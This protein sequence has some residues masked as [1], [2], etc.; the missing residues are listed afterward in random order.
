MASSESDLDVCA[1]FENS[2][3]EVTSRGLSSNAAIGG[4]RFM[5]G[6]PNM[7]ELVMNEMAEVWNSSSNIRVLTWGPAQMADQCQEQ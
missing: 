1:L 4:L 5:P 6:R 3:P 7:H 2:A